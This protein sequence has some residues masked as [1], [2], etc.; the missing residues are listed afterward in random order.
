M[1][2]ARL[3]RKQLSFP[4]FILYFKMYC[5][6]FGG[7]YMLK[8]RREGHKVDCNKYFLSKHPSSYSTDL[9]AR[10][11]WNPCPPSE[12]HLPHD[13][14]MDSNFN[15]R[16]RLKHQHFST[17]LS[18]TRCVKSLTSNI[19]HTLST[20]PERL[21][22]VLFK[23]E[24]NFEITHCFFSPRK[25]FLAWNKLILDLYSTVLI[26]RIQSN[27]FC[28]VYLSLLVFNAPGE[29]NMFNFVQSILVFSVLDSTQIFHQLI[30]WDPQLF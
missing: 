30:Q 8:G 29:S 24:D 11:I 27:Y 16:F 26:F 22:W 7:I 15:T 12:P 1:S 19:I 20:H 10:P 28:T 14:Y 5:E 18:V 17:K 9:A 13:S 4:L 6:K 2:Q 21:Q 25:V 23:W 3:A